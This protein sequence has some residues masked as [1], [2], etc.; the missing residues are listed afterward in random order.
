MLYIL[1]ELTQKSGVF[2]S[3]K[4]CYWIV[5]NWIKLKLKSNIHHMKWQSDVSLIIISKLFNTYSNITNLARSFDLNRFFFFLFVC[6][7]KYVDDKWILNNGQKK[8]IHRIRI[9]LV[10]IVSVFNLITYIMKRL[11]TRIRKTYQNPR[12]L[13]PNIFFFISPKLSV[14]IYYLLRYPFRLYTFISIP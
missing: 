4:H 12:C 9:S 6:I 1:D 8:S 2:F 10:F 7:F 14:T 13:L 5:L 3:S 11:H